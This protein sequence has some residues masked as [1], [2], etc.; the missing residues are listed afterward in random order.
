MF[1]FVLLQLQR[2]KV[3]QDAEFL[4]TTELQYLDANTVR[5]DPQE[6]KASSPKD[7]CN[8]FLGGHISIM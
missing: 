3:H 2:H 6:N 7:Y 8:A 1:Q 4:I 5:S